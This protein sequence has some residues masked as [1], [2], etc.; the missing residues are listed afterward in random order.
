LAQLGFAEA[1]R[2]APKE[3]GALNIEG[4]AA[5]PEQ[6]LLIGFR[7][8]IIRDQALLVPL[9]NPLEVIQG[10]RAQLG[11][12]IFLDLA[13]RGVRDLVFFEERYVIVAGSFD[14]SG[15]AR[16]YEWR[17][18]ATS[19]QRLNFSP[20]KQFTPEALVVY[21]ESVR[22]RYLLLSD[23]GAREIE[24]C[25]CKDLKDPARRS[26]HA[27]WLDSLVERQRPAKP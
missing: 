2:K 19:P 25:K 15:K 1:A 9:L 7:N 23:D 4:L 12:I 14:G 13:G 6:T 18:G 16:L 10:A 21:P 20:P 3:P 24:G 5:T 8:P 22:P 17:G 26:F 11:K 27:L